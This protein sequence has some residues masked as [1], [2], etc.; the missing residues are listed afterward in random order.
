MKKKITL[1]MLKALMD[2]QRNYFAWINSVILV[3]LFIQSAG[4]Y[5]WY[6]F[7]VPAAL[8]LLI[9][10]AKYILPSEVSYVHG[11]SSVFKTLLRKMENNDHKKE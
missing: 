9:I 8:V 11:K 6:L 10:D 2:R 3:Y 7:I 5:W 4:F 1:G